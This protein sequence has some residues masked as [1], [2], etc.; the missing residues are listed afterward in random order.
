L[1]PNGQWQLLLDTREG[2]VRLTPLVRPNTSFHLEARSLALFCLAEATENSTI[3][4]AA[5]RRRGA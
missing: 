4:R 3:K 5:T 1:K 2:V